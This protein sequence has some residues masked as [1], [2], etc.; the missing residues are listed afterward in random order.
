M[1][2]LLAWAQADG[3]VEVIRARRIRLGLP[4]LRGV[5]L[6]EFCDLVWLELWDDAPQLGDRSEYRDLLVKLYL[7]GV[8]PG[9]LEVTG[10]DG[11]LRKISGPRSGVTPDLKKP[12]PGYAK[13][14]L[15]EARALMAG[16][17]KQAEPNPDE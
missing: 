8:E 10:P 12:L 13:D 17:G 6:S 2:R 5:S 7:E 11:K 14:A 4:G 1:F 16:R 3:R 9:S 15:A